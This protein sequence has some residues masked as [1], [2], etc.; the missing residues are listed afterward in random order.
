[1][2][3]VRNKIL[4]LLVAILFPLCQ[5]RAGSVLIIEKK[6]GQLEE[7]KLIEEPVL[8][9]E[10]SRL[11]IESNTIET[12]YD[13]SEINRF[14]FAE[15]TTGV[16]AI[17]AKS[18]KFTQTGT[19]E[20]QIEDLDGNENIIVSNLAGR[21]FSNCV[22]KEGTVATISLSNS[23]FGVYIINIGNKQ[24]IKIIKK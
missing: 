2:N 10:G 19:N 17:K 5:S 14:Y 7:F 6:A 4:L 13:R 21:L 23:P 22:V 15:S 3:K 11:L 18:L 12:S 16:K 9:L 20:Y 24:T 1:M 8:T